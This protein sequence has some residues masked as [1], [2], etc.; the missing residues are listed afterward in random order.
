[1]LYLQLYTKTDWKYKQIF[2]CYYNWSQDLIINILFSFWYDLFDIL[3]H[4]LSHV[5]SFFHFVFI[6]LQ[7]SPVNLGSVNSEIL[8]IQTGAY[9]P[10]WAHCIYILYL[11]QIHNYM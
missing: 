5:S 4:K 3:N 7:R 2:C 8:L 11:M 9:G 10:C 6:E 1:M